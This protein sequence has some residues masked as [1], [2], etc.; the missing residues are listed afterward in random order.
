MNLTTPNRN[1]LSSQER[2]LIARLCQLLS[3]G[4]GLLRAH[5]SYHNRRCGKKWCW[6][7]KSAGPWH[8]SL[9][10]IRK[11]NRRAYSKHIGRAYVAQVEHW[12][13]RYKQAQALLQQIT[14]LYWQKLQS[15]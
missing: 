9:Y 12:N 5:L 14:D 7:A 11:A 8:R 10:A 1:H 6:C 13:R 2:E 4:K 3:Q 15:F